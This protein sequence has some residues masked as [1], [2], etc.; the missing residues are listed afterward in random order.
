MDTEEKRLLQEYNAEDIHKK[1]L[2]VCEFITQGMTLKGALT[3][4]GLTPTAF[5]KAR[6]E[7]KD[8]GQ[9]WTDAQQ[10]LAELKMSDLSALGDQLIQE[11][12]LTHNTFTAV[13]KNE[14]WIVEKLNP[15]RYGAHPQAPTTGFVQNNVQILQQLTDEQ[16]MRLAGAPAISAQNGDTLSPDKK[17]LDTPAIIEYDEVVSGDEEH[18]ANETSL[19][20][21][22]NVCISIGSADNKTSQCVN[23]AAPGP[24]SPFTNPSFDK[25][26]GYDLSA[27]GDLT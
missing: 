25:A 19:N 4:V 20:S 26:G 17:V 2:A 15:D 10:L 18:V 9:A 11:E 7:H 14:R 16:I 13:T 12:G 5:Y 24:S 8:V 3:H 6:R 23:D 21:P 1:S 27:F 22:Y